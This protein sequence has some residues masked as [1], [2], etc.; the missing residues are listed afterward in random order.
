M[1]EMKLVEKVENAPNIPI[2]VNYKKENISKISQGDLSEAKI[3]GA[4]VDKPKML[5]I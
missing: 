4:K 5:G 2:E 1:K 3:S